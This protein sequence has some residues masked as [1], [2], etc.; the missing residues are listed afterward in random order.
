[1]KSIEFIPVC[2]PFL[3]GNELKYVTDAVQTGWISS[4]GKYVKKFEETFAA[5]CG[6]QYAVSVCNGTAAV[7]LALVTLG[8]QKDDEVII[9]NFTMIATALGLCYIGAKPVFIDADPDTWNIDASRIEEKITPKTKAI[10]PVHIY[11]N[12]CDM[13]KIA[14]IAHKYNLRIIEDAAESHG[15]LYK[16]KKAGSISDMGAF[17]FYANKNLTAGDGGMIVTNSEE[18]Y[19]KCLYYKNLC[20]PLNAPRNFIHQNIGFNYRMSNLSA[21]IGL[22]QVEK[23]DEYREMRIRNF[24][25]Y[26]ERLGKIDGI[27]FQKDQDSAL[28][29]RWM[30]GILLDPDIFGRTRDE[31][32]Y[33]LREKNIDT[34]LFFTGMHRQP[35]LIDFGCDGASAYPV[36][37]NLSKNGFYLPSGSNLKKEQIQYICESIKV[38]KK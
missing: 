31:L 32:V 16:G 10:I 11:G 28:N 18:L 7:H 23:A 36:T 21:A 33:A 30:N 22:A 9:P 6:T 34:R 27:S 14:A 12:P 29:V 37:E 25:R 8:I 17:S 38:L 4:S 19:Q 13:D 5:Y 2:E 1:M 24:H 15:A 26:Q 3:N 20:F 35:A